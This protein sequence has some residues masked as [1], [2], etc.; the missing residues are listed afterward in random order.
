MHTKRLI[1]RLSSL[2]DVILASSALEVVQAD[3]SLDWVVAEEFSELLRHHPKIN[4]VHAFNRSGNLRT[5]IQLCRKL[6]EAQYD[7]IFDLHRSLRT[8]V[9]KLFFIFWSLKEGVSLPHWKTV[10]KQRGRL[11]LYYFVK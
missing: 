10:K 6:W 2:G 5:W 9:M 7:Q 1:L 3:S 8:G 4:Q 11:Y